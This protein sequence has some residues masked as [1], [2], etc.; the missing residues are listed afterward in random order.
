MRPCNE[1][2]ATDNRDPPLAPLNGFETRDCLHEHTFHASDN[3]REHRWKN[4]MG[5]LFH[6]C[7]ESRPDKTWGIPEIV[8]QAIGTLNMFCNSAPGETGRY[9]MMFN[10]R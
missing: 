8:V 6:G 4:A 2:R 9:H 5:F 3:T 10:R 7:H 1:C